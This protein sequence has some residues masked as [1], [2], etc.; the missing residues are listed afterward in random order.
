MGSGQKSPQILQ[1]PVPFVYEF[2]APDRFWSSHGN[3]SWLPV[4]IPFR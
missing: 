1:E 2:P 3:G 4:Y